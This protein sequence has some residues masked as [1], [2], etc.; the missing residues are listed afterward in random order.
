MS[1]NN[2]YHG[3]GNAAMFDE[4]M[5]FINYVFGFNG[6]SHDFK[7]LLPK[8]YKPELDPAGHSYVTVEN[9]KIKAA[10]G[11]YDHDLTVCGETLKARG[12]G[13]VAVHPYERS[14][15]FMKK[16]MNLALEDMVKEG[17]A[18]SVLGGR[19]QR[20]RYFSFDKLGSRFSMS[21]N[22]DNIRHTF[23]TSFEPCFDF[24]RIGPQ[25]TESLDGIAK[26]Y[27]S[28]LLHCERPREML[29]DILV[30]W[31]TK[32]YAA[33][34]KKDGRFAGYFVADDYSVSEFLIDDVYRP[35]LAELVRDFFK[36]L[37]KGKLVLCIPLHLSA[38][39]E[40]LIDIGEHYDVAPQKSF[41]ILDFEKVTRAFMK[42]KATY[43][44]LCDGR[45]AVKIDGYAKEETLLISVK[46]GVPSVEPTELEP[47]VELSHIEAMNLLF[48]PFRP[49][50]ERLPQAP[51]SWFPLPLFL[52]SA[53]AV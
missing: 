34:F 28:S 18:M 49:E 8:L 51:R 39:I 38:Y 46:D 12:I 30:S 45:F 11:A 19:R 37:G 35:W 22:D 13:N 25:D 17:V 9:G 31:Q 41:N 2:I 14:R 3:L 10:V 5:D 50:R 40:T 44:E 21:I 6:N 16:L 42:L 7:K 15:G 24:R 20:Y 23:G 29:Y 52:Y 47:D 53:D 33:Y 27:G 1:E 36:Y 48:A 43:S 32:V 4:Y 26:L